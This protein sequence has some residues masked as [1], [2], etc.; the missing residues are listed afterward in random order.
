MYLGLPS[1]TPSGTIFNSLKSSWTPEEFLYISIGSSR[2]WS[3]WIWLW[4]Q[5]ELDTRR[6]NMIPFHPV[7]QSMY[8]SY[9][10]WQGG[11]DH[12][13]H[14]WTVPQ[15]TPISSSF[16]AP[17]LLPFCERT[18]N[19]SCCGF[20]SFFTTFNHRN[21]TRPIK[22]TISF[23][24]HWPIGRVSDKSRTFGTLHLERRCN[25]HGAIRFQRSMC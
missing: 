4:I 10:R 18:N 15:W 2:T 17:R 16:K 11:C 5:Y 1:I 12:S 21:E 13:K 7:S 6:Y 20:P 23:G 8:K 9:T 22:A 3:V 19:A 25:S 14:P 24:I